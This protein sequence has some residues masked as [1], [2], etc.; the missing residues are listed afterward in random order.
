L[1]IRK[2]LDEFDEL[3]SEK[4]G[5]SMISNKSEKE[6]FGEHQVEVKPTESEQEIASEGILPAESKP[7]EPQEGND[8]D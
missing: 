5:D 2:N 6:F 3:A 8:F 1:I 7:Q 4:M